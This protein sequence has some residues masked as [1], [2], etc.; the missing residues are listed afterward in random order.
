MIRKLLFCD[1]S[2]SVQLRHTVVNEETDM[3][4]FVRFLLRNKQAVAI[5]TSLR[6]GQ[7]DMRSP[8]V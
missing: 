4:K 1:L 6:A 2:Q 8:R 3:R 5:W 7:P